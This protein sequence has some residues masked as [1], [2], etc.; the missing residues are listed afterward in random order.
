LLIEWLKLYQYQK[1]ITGGASGIGKALAIQ[2]A[3][4][5][6]F[7]IIAD[8]NETCGQDNLLLFIH[9]MKTDEC[10]DLNNRSNSRVTLHKFV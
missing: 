5:D 1:I 8:I 2:L 4:K 6:I 10:K 7:V 3:N 9:I